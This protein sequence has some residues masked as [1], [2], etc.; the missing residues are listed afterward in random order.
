MRGQSAHPAFLDHVGVGID[1]DRGNPPRAQEVEELA[2]AAAHVEHVGCAGEAIDVV[3]LPRANLGGGSAEQIL[4][5]D[6]A[7]AKRAVLTG[8]H[9][10]SARF[11][12]CSFRRHRGDL[13]LPPR[14]DGGAVRGRGR[15]AHFIER[16]LQHARFRV[17]VGCDLLQILH[18]DRVERHEGVE[19]GLLRGA[20]LGERGRQALKRFRHALE[21]RGDLRV[22][23][24]LTCEYRRHEPPHEAREAAAE[25]RSIGR[26]RGQ[27]AEAIANR[28]DVEIDRNGRRLLAGGAWQRA[29]D[30]GQRFVVL[31]V[32]RIAFRDATVDFAAVRHG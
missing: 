31:P 32:G 16:R 13:E 28:G 15:H 5:S 24:L 29:I 8:D 10:W 11:E 3:G 19:F 12:T 18:Q 14:G 2:A 17:D 22:E 26:L 27:D 7:G 6:V 30:V 9:C 25:P 23:L 4:E 21:M 1:A 20:R